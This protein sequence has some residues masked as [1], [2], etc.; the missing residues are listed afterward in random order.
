MSLTTFH[1]RQSPNTFV[2]LSTIRGCNQHYAH[3]R[4]LRGGRCAGTCYL[5]RHSAQKLHPARRVETGEGTQVIDWEGCKA[6]LEGENSGGKAVAV[7]DKATDERGTV[8]KNSR[9]RNKYRKLI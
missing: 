6:T 2:V 5:R 9:Q 8:D 3:I 1:A 4:N 7:G